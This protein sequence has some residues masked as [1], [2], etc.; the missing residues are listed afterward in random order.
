MHERIIQ[1]ML[2]YKKVFHIY[3]NTLYVGQDEYMEIIRSKAINDGHIEYLS[4]NII[5]V[6]GLMLCT[7]GVKSH[8]FIAYNEEF[9]GN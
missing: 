2:G 5:R 8:F 9:N 3:P 7:V 1:A 6:C 4:D